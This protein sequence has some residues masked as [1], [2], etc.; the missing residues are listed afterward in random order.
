MKNV[1]EIAKCLCNKDFKQKTI[2]L[3]DLNDLAQKQKKSYHSRR[4][5]VNKMVK[6]EKRFVTTVKW[7]RF[8]TLDD[9]SFKRK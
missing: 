9:P 6:V 8:F 4:F 5:D 7:K 1:F 3:D 2:S